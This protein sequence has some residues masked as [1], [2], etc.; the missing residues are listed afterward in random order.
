M[1][2]EQVP[3]FLFIDTIILA[4][5]LGHVRY[6]EQKRVLLQAARTATD[7]ISFMAAV[8]SFGIGKR[9]KVH[10]AVGQ[11]LS[12]HSYYRVKYARLLGIRSEGA[13]AEKFLDNPYVLF[14]T[15]GVLT[16]Q[17][18]QAMYKAYWWVVHNYRPVFVDAKKGRCIGMYA[19]DPQDNASTLQHF[20]AHLN[21][22]IHHKNQQICK[23]FEGFPADI[24]MAILRRAFL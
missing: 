13:E 3:D 17:Q 7:T 20:E 24:V 21:Y 16:Y 8:E 18:Q 15:E 5:R 10:T 2:A 19:T 12:S 14:L 23:P 11:L 6:D 1:S 9:S 4:Y 22:L